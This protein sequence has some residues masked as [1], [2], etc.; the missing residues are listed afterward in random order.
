LIDKEIHFSYTFLLCSLW[1]PAKAVGVG[2]TGN[3]ENGSDQHSECRDKTAF[4]IK[5][6]Q[7]LF[8]SGIQ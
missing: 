7:Y 4:K 1:D 8:Y 3:R 2:T 6:A 5:P